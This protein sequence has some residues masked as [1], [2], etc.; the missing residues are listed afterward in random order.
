MGNIFSFFKSPKGAKEQ[1]ERL[2]NEIDKIEEHRISAV[3]KERSCNFALIV[4]SVIVYVIG[5]IY[6]YFD[7]NHSKSI[8]YKG[9]ALSFL[10]L[11]PLIV[12]YARSLVGW[13]YKWVR[14]TNDLNYRALL[15]MKKKIISKVQET[16]TFNDA[17]MIL[18]KFDPSALREMSRS[19]TNLS[20]IGSDFQT[21]SFAVQNRRS[22]RTASQPTPRPQIMPNPSFVQQQT[23]RPMLAILP[24]NAQP[25]FNNTPLRPLQK[26]VKPILPQ[27]RSVVEKAVDYM[28]GDGP[29]N[30]FALICSR[31]NSHNGMALPAEFEYI[32][33]ICAYCGF[34]N[35]ARKVRPVAAKMEDYN[36]TKT[37]EGPHIEEASDD[38]VAGPKI[39]EISSEMN[40]S[41]EANVSEQNAT[42]T[43]RPEPIE[44]ELEETKH[45][46]ENTESVLQDSDP[47]LFA[48]EDETQ[49]RSENPNT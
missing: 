5:L 17:K 20:N 46:E 6:L 29:S 8:T 38:T 24:A 41:V 37:I 36:T 47:I 49:T 34:Y 31:C 4:S 35:P 26:T 15:K 19:F 21:P 3:V 39:T 48:D 43:E 1:L 28:F 16:E 14:E 18:E 44:K 2:Q 40:K 7:Y 22:F 42:T 10:I 13:Y 33:Y 11:I 9:F 45:H 27:N 23:N 32:S 30:R 25:Q 12:Y